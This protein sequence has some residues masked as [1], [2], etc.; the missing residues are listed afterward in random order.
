VNTKAIVWAANVH[1]AKNLSVVSGLEQRV[2]LGSYIRRDA[3]DRSFALG[4]SAHAGSYSMARQPVRQLSVAPPASLEGQAFATDSAETRYFTLGQLR[5]LGAAP[6]RLTGLDFRTA[7][8]ND[9]FDGVVLF[10]EER[11]PDFSR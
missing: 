5:S 3:A 2:P 10:R 7:R 8:W 6:A 1:V 11:P 9:V 4:F